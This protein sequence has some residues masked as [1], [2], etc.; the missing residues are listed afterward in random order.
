MREPDGMAAAAELADGFAAA[1]RADAG[2]AAAA[3]LLGHCGICCAALNGGRRTGNATC[4]GAPSLPEEESES[5]ASLSN[6]S[7]SS[8][9]E[10]RDSAAA[11]D[12]EDAAA[13]GAAAVGRGVVARRARGDLRGVLVGVEAVE[14]TLLSARAAAAAITA[15]AGSTTSLRFR[16]FFA[17]LAAGA[18]RVS[19]GMELASSRVARA[20]R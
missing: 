18:A 9:S 8:S 10:I 13:A 17:G 14:S 2:A 4:R 15:A 7:S 1:D 12:D 11:A 6:S 16:A 3:V 19:V 20:P 5:E